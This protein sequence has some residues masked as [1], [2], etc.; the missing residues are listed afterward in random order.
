MYSTRRHCA[1]DKCHQAARESNNPH[2][3]V[4]GAM[5]FPCMFAPRIAP[6]L[7]GPLLSCIRHANSISLHLCARRTLNPPARP[8][9]E[10]P[11]RRQ[12]APPVQLSTI[13]PATTGSNKHSCT[14]TTLTL[15]PPEPPCAAS[16]LCRRTAPRARPSAARLSRLLRRCSA[17]TT[18]KSSAAA[19]L[20]SARLPAAAPVRL[21]AG[22][23]LGGGSGARLRLVRCC[24]GTRRLREKTFVFN[25]LLAL[26]CV[27]QL[28]W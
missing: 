23:R 17:E 7:R 11:Y 5:P 13:Q 9:A 14:Y 27:N 12:N 28:A 26:L 20:W 6:R 24:L 22:Q 8:C 19:R 1:V 2:Q 15:S 3:T 25:L 21:A 4:L 16:R 18:P 10:R